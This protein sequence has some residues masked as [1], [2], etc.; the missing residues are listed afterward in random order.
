MT[1]VTVNNVY[2]DLMNIN[3][4]SKPK[5]PI[6][7]CSFKN[8]GVKALY[9]TGSC[10]T[11]MSEDTYHKLS[12]SEQVFSEPGRS[13]LSASGDRMKT[14]G[15]IN[16]KMGIEGKNVVQTVHV[17]PKLHEPFILGIDFIRDIVNQAAP[18]ENNCSVLNLVYY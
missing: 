16:L 7:R 12:K 10:V 5:R 13:F 14:H 18:K 2:S 3:A 6:T 8:S 1:P 15:A 11:C 4:I 9:D 17:I